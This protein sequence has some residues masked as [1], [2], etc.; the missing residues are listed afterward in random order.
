[1]RNNVDSRLLVNQKNLCIRN[2]SH[3]SR[4]EMR[5]TRN[6]FDHSKYGG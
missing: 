5:K 1:M 6:M 3:H 2:T 4:I